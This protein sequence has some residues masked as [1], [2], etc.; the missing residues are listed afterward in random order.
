MCRRYVVRDSNKPSASVVEVDYV[1]SKTSLL[2]SLIGM[3]FEG[4]E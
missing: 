1:D 3:E 2:E 4:M